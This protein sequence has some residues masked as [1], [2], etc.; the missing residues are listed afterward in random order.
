L[1]LVLGLLV[2][3]GGRSRCEERRTLKSDPSQEYYV[4]LPSEYDA[5]KQYWLFVGVHGLG[6]NG[7]GALGW[8]KFA[9]EGQC[10]VV[11]PT[12]KGKYQFPTT[13]SGVGRNMIAIFKEMSRKHKLQRKL[14]ITGFSAGA[15]FAHR[16]TLAAP[17][18]VLACAPHSAGSWSKPSARV[19]GV[20]FVVTCG[21]DDRERIEIART[22]AEQ[23][24]R[25]GC[26]VTSEWYEGVGHSMCG[27]CR[28]ITK[29]L[30]FA[31]TNGMSLELYR[32][33]LACVDE[34]DKFL[35]E[36]QYGKAVAELGK[37]ARSKRKGAIFEKARARI[38]EIEEAGRN[39]VAEAEEEAATDRSAAAGLLEKLAQAYRGTRVA[40][41][42]A[43]ALKKVKAGGPIVAKPPV[44]GK[45]TEPAPPKPAEP[46]K[47]ETPAARWLSVAR[48]YLESDD[49]AKAVEYLKKIIDTYPD[50]PEAGEA[51]RLIDTM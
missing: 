15:Q 2:A 24:K 26:R 28:K 22:F 38:R 6:G 47:P 12:F 37:L 13:S 9:D 1:A 34:A 11:G 29:E 7:K 45:E 20:P 8:A 19:R 42:A 33:A 50:S 16:F 25:V 27:D 21:E 18:L 35:A 23:L 44:T 48:S 51:H 40:P 10:I 46:P 49:K 43:A 32:K 4:T 14:F 17:Q 5:K 36:Q 31:A 41:V 30:F 3:C 39:K